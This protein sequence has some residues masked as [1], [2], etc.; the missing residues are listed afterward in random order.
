MQKIIMTCFTVFLL[1]TAPSLVSVSYANTSGPTV[2]TDQKIELSLREVEIAEA[3]QML[4]KQQRVNI[5]LA[6]GVSGKVSINLYDM[7]LTEAI[8]L[9]A[10]TAGYEAEKRGNSYFIINRDDVGS[11]V[12]NGTT[13]IVTFNL[14]YAKAEDVRE[15]LGEYISNYGSITELK[16][17]NILVVQDKP[18]FL[19]KIKNLVKKLDYRPRQIVIEARILEITLDDSEA[20]GIE[21]SKLFSTGGGGD[22]I[23]GRGVPANNLSGLFLEII[24]D[25]WRVF[26]DL[27]QRE[28]RTKTLSTPK[29]L[30]IENNKASVIVGDRLG[31]VNTVTINQVTTENTEFL[32][33]GVILE[34]TP[35]VDEYGRILLKI[36]PEVS[37]GTV[38]D[39]IPSQTTTAVDTHLLVPN[40]ATSFIGGLIK[41]QVFKDTTGVPVISK[42]PLLGKLFTRKENRKINTEIIVMITP[43]IVET[44]DEKWQKGEMERVEE[45]QKSISSVTATP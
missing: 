22:G 17:R 32:E 7:S 25:D 41:T 2:K 28:G 44:S 16:D 36:H 18:E 45:F 42:I 29:L 40:G 23:V 19:K 9:I 33:S 11:Y 20:Y 38:T 27:L 13:E 26:L 31:Y 24:D 39:G 8:Q 21:W 4:S 15:I 3:M 30:T 43:T 5:L 10:N 34:V 14:H 12:D 1:S 37:T 6:K 35:S